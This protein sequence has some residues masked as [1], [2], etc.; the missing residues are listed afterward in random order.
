[1]ATSG[2]FLMAMDMATLAED[3]RSWTHIEFLARLV[4]EEAHTARNRRLAA[5]V[6]FAR[7]RST[8]RST[9]STS[10]SNRP[11]AGASCEGEPLLDRAQAAPR[12]SPSTLCRGARP[13]P[14][15]H[16]FRRRSLSPEDRRLGV[17]HGNHASPSGVG[18]GRLPT[19]RPAE[20]QEATA[21]GAL[22][23][24]GHTRVEVIPANPLLR[25]SG[26]HPRTF[27][28]RCS[29]LRGDD[30]EPTLVRVDADGLGQECDD[31]GE[32][33]PG[34]ARCGNAPRGVLGPPSQ[35]KAPANGAA[36]FAGEP[37]ALRGR[38]RPC[39][40]DERSTSR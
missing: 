1:M 4:A 10:T 30:E 25:T 12:E 39:G 2:D 22:T 15:R 16:A 36:T 9:S 8:G 18:R 20:V 5:R 35:P 37:G 40:G 21:H 6:R 7:F 28:A 31:E 13:N 32:S 11:S 23:D 38:R 3:A 27:L 33:R 34:R 29:D 14:E 19:S 24:R 17:S 26:R